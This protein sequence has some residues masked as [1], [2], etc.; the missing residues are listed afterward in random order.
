MRRCERFGTRA[1]DYGLGQRADRLGRRY[2]HS[3]C[4]NGFV[5]GNG[6]C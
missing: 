2:G 1:D 4:G 3:L 5:H 6:N